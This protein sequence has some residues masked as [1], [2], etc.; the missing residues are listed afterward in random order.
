MSGGT[1]HPGVGGLVGGREGI[2]KVDS[3]DK[4]STGSV[5]HQTR[6]KASLFLVLT[7]YRYPLTGCAEMINRSADRAEL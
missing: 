7:S 2:K 6:W 3:S 1:A 5:P 4:Q